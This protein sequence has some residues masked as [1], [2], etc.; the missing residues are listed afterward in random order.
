MELVHYFGGWVEGPRKQT[1]R[2][3]GVWVQSTF[4]VKAEQIKT[5]SRSSFGINKVLD[6]KPLAPLFSTSMPIA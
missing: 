5:M 2:T 1:D 3:Y 6:V 4:G